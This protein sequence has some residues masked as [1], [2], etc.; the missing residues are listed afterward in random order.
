MGLMMPHMA[1]LAGGADH[2]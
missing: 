2:R 1:R